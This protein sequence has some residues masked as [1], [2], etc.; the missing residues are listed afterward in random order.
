[1]TPAP[2][3]TQLG[4]AEEADAAARWVAFWDGRY[5]FYLKRARAVEKK[6]RRRVYFIPQVDRKVRMEGKVLWQWRAPWRWKVGGAGAKRRGRRS[7]GSG[8]RCR[9]GW[10]TVGGN[11]RTW[12]EASAWTITALQSRKLVAPYVWQDRDAGVGWQIEWKWDV[13]CGVIAGPRGCR[14]VG[15]SLG[16]TLSQEATVA[17]REAE[18]NWAWDQYCLEAKAVALVKW[19]A[20]RWWARLLGDYVSLRVVHCHPVRVAVRQWRDNLD[21]V[22]A[23]EWHRLMTEEDFKDGYRRKHVLLGLLMAQL[24]GSSTVWEDTCGDE[25]KEPWEVLEDYE[26]RCETER[27]V[28]GTPYMGIW[29]A[30]GR[31]FNTWMLR[32]CPWWCVVETEV[33]NNGGLWREEM[34]SEVEQHNSE[35]ARRGEEGPNRST[36]RMGIMRVRKQFKKSL[37]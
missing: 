20:M 26:W 35:C 30:A 8:E 13:G 11:K 36:R 25:V 2:R 23:D 34:D 3:S 27:G 1:M 29:G 7:D 17:D 14:K 33:A 37:C 6:A 16:L 10:Y 31:A 19:R 21:D 5:A 15:Q 4:T 28:L 9:G 18:A 24:I 12:A 22:T 32:G